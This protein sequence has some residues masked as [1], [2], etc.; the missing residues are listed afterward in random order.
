[1]FHVWYSF[2][3]ARSMHASQVQTMHGDYNTSMHISCIKYVYAMR[4][5]MRIPCI[6]P[7]MG[8]V[9]SL[10]TLCMDCAYTMQILCM[11][12]VQT[13]HYSGIGASLLQLTY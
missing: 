13:L 6:P 3:C 12:Y 2:E 10:H 4:E 7:C 9:N 11:T 5:L 8:C 1:M